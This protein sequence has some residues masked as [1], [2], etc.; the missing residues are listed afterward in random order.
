MQDIYFVPKQPSEN[1]V[2]FLNFKAISSEAVLPGCS[3]KYRK[4]KI[5]FNDWNRYIKSVVYLFTMVR[6]DT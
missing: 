5:P 2:V 3:K 4:V 6:I 1:E